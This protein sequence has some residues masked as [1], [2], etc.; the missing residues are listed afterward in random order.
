MSKEKYNQ[1]FEL[2]ESI[3]SQMEEMSGGGYI[4]FILDA[5]NTP[6][7]YESFDGYGQESQ[8][9]N[10]ALDF[11][12]AEREARKEIFKRDIIANM[13]NQNDDDEEEEEGDQDNTD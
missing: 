1:N 3:L 13:E 4:I 2:P 9:K 5:G 8:V 7:V 11:L 10:F 12:Q 6:S